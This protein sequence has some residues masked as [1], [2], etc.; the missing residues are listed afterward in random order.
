VFKKV[1]S[2]AES[3]LSVVPGDIVM[4]KI[5]LQWPPDGYRWMDDALGFLQPSLEI[6][7]ITEKSPV[8]VIS[9]SKLTQSFMLST[10]HETTKLW[11]GIS[12]HVLHDERLWWI[13]Y[14]SNTS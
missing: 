1:T 10:K 11:L 13:S 6:L 2:H 5:L 4:G 12:A 8:L 9:I 3:W 7:T 14:K